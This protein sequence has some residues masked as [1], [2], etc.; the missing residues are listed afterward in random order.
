MDIGNYFHRTKKSSR[1]TVSEGH[2]RPSIF[3]VGTNDSLFH[4]SQA[5]CPRMYYFSQTGLMV[6]YS[7]FALSEW[8]LV[9]LAAGFDAVSILDFGEFELQIVKRRPAGIEESGILILDSS[10][11]SR[12]ENL[13][14]FEG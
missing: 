4:P 14:D 10:V 8:T 1:T 3:H 11:D 2:R 13:M 6:A 7:V 12:S 9:F 5:G